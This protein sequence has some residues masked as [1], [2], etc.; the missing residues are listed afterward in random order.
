MGTPFRYPVVTLCY[1]DTAALDLQNQTFYVLQEIIDG[2]DV[3]V[4]QFKALDLGL[5]GSR[6]S[7]PACSPASSSPG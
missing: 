5:G 3:V 6:V 1:G 7:Q 4:R 2:V